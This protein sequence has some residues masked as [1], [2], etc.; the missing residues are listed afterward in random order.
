MKRL[1][2]TLRCITGALA[3]GLA[4]AWTPAASAQEQDW[5]LAGTVEINSTQMAFILSGK[6]GGG[7]LEFE[8]E[9]YYF[10]IGGLGIGGVGV[11]RLNAV[12]AVYNMDDVSKFAGTYV[13]AR[14]GATLVKGKGSMRLSNEHGVI[15]SLKASSKGV[16][17]AI[18]ADG[19]IVS[20]K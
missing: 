15:L 3:I 6:L 20:M 7:V 8:G 19:L 4:T 18:G 9:E 17:L 5:E 2:T 13:Q 12:G 1:T 11:Q 16:A 10:N 14:M